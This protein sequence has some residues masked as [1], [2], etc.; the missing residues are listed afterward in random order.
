[1]ETSH[2]SRG[3]A[4]AFRH[5]TGL[6]DEELSDLVATVHDLIGSWK[7]ATDRRKALGLFMAIVVV[8]F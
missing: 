2:I 7:P 8:L 5:C 1:M 4:P 6:D 3:R